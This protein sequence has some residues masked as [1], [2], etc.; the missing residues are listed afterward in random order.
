MGTLDL[1]PAQRFGFGDAHVGTRE[2]DRAVGG[3]G[4]QQ[5][6]GGVQTLD[7]GQSVGAAFGGLLRACGSPARSPRGRHHGDDPV[8]C[9]LEPG[10]VGVPQVG[11]VAVVTWSSMRAAG[12]HRRG[13]RWPERARRCAA[14][15]TTGFVF[16]LPGLQGGLLGE[17][18]RLDHRR[19]P[20]VVTLEVGDQGGAT[21]FDVGATAGPAFI[22]LRRH[23]RQFPDGPLTGVGGGA[24]CEPESVAFEQLHQGCVVLLGGGNRAA[25]QDATVDRQPLPGDGGLHLVGHRHVSVQVGI[26]GPGVP[27][28]EGRRHQPGHVHLPHPTGALAGER[29]RDSM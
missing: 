18:D 13:L 9:L 21:G 4:H 25:I 1:A 20:A 6:D 8:G 17:L 23:P 3:G 2:Q 29:R 24:V 12:P 16:G 26:A 14:R 19:E 27:V 28:R 7:D 10:G 5:V 11:S 15:P 22:Q